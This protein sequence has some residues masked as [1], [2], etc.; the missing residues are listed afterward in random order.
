MNNT[1]IQFTGYLY[2]IS[3]CFIECTKKQGDET[4]K[5]RKEIIRSAAA[6]SLAAVLV[7][8][9][10]F[11]TA[12]RIMGSGICSGFDLLAA[13]STLSGGRYYETGAFS[14]TRSDTHESSIPAPEIS[15]INEEQEAVLH[16]EKM[17]QKKAEFESRIPDENSRKAYDREHAGEEKYPVNEFTITQG[18]IAYSGVQVKNSSSFD[19]DIEKELRGRLGFTIDKGNEPQVLIYHTHTHESFLEYD[20]GYYYESFYPRSDDPEKNVCAVGKEIADRLN[21]AG[22]V[23]IHDTTVHD[24]TYSG[25][26]DRSYDTISSYL[27][28]YPSIKVVLDIHRDGLGTDTSRSKPV[29]DANGKKAAQIM[30]LAGY[31]YEDADYFKDWEY[32]LR[33][34]LQ[35]QKKV[36]ETY[37]DMLRPV[38]FGNFMYNMNVNTGSLLIEIG[39]DSNT[40]E[41]VR[42]TGW[43]LGGMLGEMLA[44]IAEKS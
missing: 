20:T 28:K 44:D 31:N 2:N 11:C 14:K 17:P 39:A 25:A 13:Q 12:S 26:Y 4:L 34:A 40:V 7:L 1:N 22:I 32:N 19:L 37:P 3:S 16:E 21:E 30:I 6:A 23:A 15:D 42:Y 8:C 29:F 10:V 27:K 43:L 41:E 5:R 35:L 36:L 33:F 38:Y 24:D 9:A 18:D